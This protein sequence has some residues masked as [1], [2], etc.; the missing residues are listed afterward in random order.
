M[1]EL[2]Y[3]EVLEQILLEYTKI[4]Y[5]FGDITTEA[6]F[7]HDKDRYL[8]VNVGWDQGK[9]IHGSL[10][11]IDI[12]DGKFW[13]QRDGTEE[14]IAVALTR[15]GIPKDHIVLAF[16]PPEMRIHTGFAVA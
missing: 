5:A 10:V 15:A 12:I 14:G 2:N 9:R 7:D 13:I 8:L 6:V 11:H 1:A 16:R 3:R 4:P